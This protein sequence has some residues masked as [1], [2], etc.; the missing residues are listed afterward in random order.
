MEIE[1]VEHRCWILKQFSNAWILILSEKKYIKMIIR[2]EFIQYLQKKLYIIN[3][4]F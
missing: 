3:N 2:V 1:E 4:F